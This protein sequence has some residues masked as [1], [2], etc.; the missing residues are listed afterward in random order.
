MTARVWV[1]IFAVMLLGACTRPPSERVQTVEKIVR[2][3]RAPDKLIERGK[4]FAMIGD[5]TRASQYFSAA[6]DEGADEKTV[7]PLLMHTYVVS[8]R[9][10]V[11]IR[12]GE[13]YVRS[14]PFDYRLRYLVGTLYAAVGDFQKAREQFE[15][16]LT[17]D[18]K[19]AQAHYALAVLLRDDEN[20]FIGADYHFRQ[21]LKLAPEGPHAEEA[22]ASLL[23]RVP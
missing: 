20:D 23:K 18:P 11:A 9:Y 21:Y 19:H 16:V 2:K 14:H 4:A 10:L 3:E 15:Q 8:Q 13:R 5:Y 22:R 6:L 7:L 17:I 1:T 12:V